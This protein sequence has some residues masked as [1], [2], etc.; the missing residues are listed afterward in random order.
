M[1]R[2]LSDNLSWAYIQAANKLN[3]KQSKRRIVA[4]VESYD[5]VFFWRSILKN[6]ENDRLFFEIMLPTRNTHLE[7][8]K[9][10]VLMQLIGD[11]VGE[12]MIACVDADY[13]YL[14]NGLTPSSKMV[15]ENPFVF[16]TYA[17][18]IENLQCYAASLHEVCVGV[19]LN[20]R[21]LFD[22]HRFLVQ[23]SR[24]I[25]PLFVWSIWHYR[26]GHY[27][28]FSITDFARVTDIGNF[29]IRR[30]PQILSLLSQRVKKKIAVFQQSYPDCQPDWQ[31]LNHELADLGITPD[32]T[33]LYIQG[34]HLMDKVVMPIMQKVCELLVQD[35]QTEISRQSIHA[36]QRRNE[37]AAYQSRIDEISFV[38]KKNTGYLMSEECKKIIADLQQFVNKT[39]AGT[40]TKT[41]YALSSLQNQ[42]KEKHHI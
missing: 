27:R 12:D 10:A 6:V 21:L 25:H 17:Y 38:I 29:S 13:D 35:R 11:K 5:D 42:T 14:M 40:A 4:Y 36:T 41:Q 9:K 8:G 39:E 31:A 19:T 7:R 1:A 23:Y 15:I 28:E 34:H 33:Y 22:V 16:H 26:F 30:T 20:D 32:N 2:R 3:S 18:S 24:I 37:L